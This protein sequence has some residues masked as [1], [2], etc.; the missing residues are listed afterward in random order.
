MKKNIINTASIRLIATLAGIAI[1]AMLV[2][3]VLLFGEFI[4]HDN[5]YLFGRNA[6]D[7]FKLM[8]GSLIPIIPLFGAYYFS[9]KETGEE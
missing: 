9:G 5:R 3:S 7:Y 4:F 1:L 8:A 6:T 2:G